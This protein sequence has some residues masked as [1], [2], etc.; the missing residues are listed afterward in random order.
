MMPIVNH[1]PIH[2]GVLDFLKYI[3]D[4]FKTE[5][6]KLITGMNCPTDISE[7]YKSFRRTFEHFSNMPNIFNRV[8]RKKDENGHYISQKEKIIMHHYI[9]SFDPKEKISPEQANAIGVE[10]A[11]KVFGDNYQV[12]VS[13]HVDKE[14][15][16]NHIAV[17]P[18]SLDGKKWNSDETTLKYCRKVSDEIALEH[19]LSIIKNSKTK[20]HMKYKEWLERQNGT[21][22][23]MQ[24][25]EKIDKL[26]LQDNVNTLE[27]LQKELQKEKYY[28]RLGKY[29][30]IKPPDRERSIRTD[31]LDRVYGG[32]SIREIEYRLKHKNKEISNAAISRLS[33]IEREYAIYMR[34]LQITVFKTNG[35][36][37]KNKTYRHLV[38]SADLLTYITFNNVRSKEDLERLKKKR[39]DEYNELSNAKRSL[40]RR[41]KKLIEE[42]K[43]DNDIQIKELQKELEIINN[44]FEITYNKMREAERFY[45]QYKEEYESDD[46]SIAKKEYEELQAMLEENSDN[47]RGIDAY[48]SEKRFRRSF[49]IKYSEYLLL[50]NGISHI[51]ILVVNI[52]IYRCRI[53]TPVII[54]LFLAY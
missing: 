15:T 43:T 36:Q 26:I 13:T 53:V 39:K 42:Q 31:N 14:H 52:I 37:D 5:G 18:Y 10:W 1:I 32:Y 34:T 54:K 24:L 22:W 19:G 47:D 23:K 28:V 44:G 33:G 3:E 2:T 30:T 46:Y 40:E 7:A 9:Q 17:C 45:E 48:K 20:N 27:D 4:A 25:C 11:K 29:M 8:A 41:I 12:I 6:Q 49:I 51:I 35:K 38:K 16:H 50:L 21:S